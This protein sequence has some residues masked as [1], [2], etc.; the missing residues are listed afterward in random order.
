MAKIIN[1]SNLGDKHMNSLTNLQMID[2]SKINVCEMVICGL[3]LFAIC[4]GS[5]VLATHVSHEVAMT[6]A[7]LYKQM[8]R[9]THAMQSIR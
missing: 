6:K 3:T 5:K 2:I 8:I 7:V 4:Y 9:A 1:I